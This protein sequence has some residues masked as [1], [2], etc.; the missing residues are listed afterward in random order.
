MPG[1]RR[2]DPEKS[3]ALESV[4]PQ[5]RTAIRNAA[6][7]SCHLTDRIHHFRSVDDTG[8][9]CNSCLAASVPNRSG[10][11][12]TTVVRDAVGIHRFD[13]I[14]VSMAERNGLSVDCGLFPGLDRRDRNLFTQPLFLR[15]FSGRSH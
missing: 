13:L 4:D 2:I 15:T 11:A 9:Q 14:P 10:A 3:R 1:S 8:L 6:A 12:W 7:I 5:S